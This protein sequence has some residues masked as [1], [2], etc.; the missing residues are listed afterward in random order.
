MG[1]EREGRER[2]GRRSHAMNLN[3]ECNTVYIL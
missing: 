2:E 3:D 1:R